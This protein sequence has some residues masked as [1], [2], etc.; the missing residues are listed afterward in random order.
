MAPYVEDVW[1]L[2]RRFSSFRAA[3]VPWEENT[4]V[5]K[6]SQLASRQE[7][8]P[9][10][11]YIEVLKRPSVSPERLKP[12]SSATTGAGNPSTPTTRVASLEAQDP[13]VPAVEEA[14]LPSV[15]AVLLVERTH[16]PWAQDVV[17]Y[18]MEHTL[19]EDDHEAERVARRAKLYVLIEIGRASC[20]ERVFR[21][22]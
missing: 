2:Q 17:K 9:P 5:D 10:G 7:P 6:L 21:A 16:P 22:V 4:S 14:L 18:M 20:R 15:Q 12:S 8:V 11:I 3:Y 19:P 1:K 13:A